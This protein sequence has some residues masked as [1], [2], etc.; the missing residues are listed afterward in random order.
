MRRYLLLLL[1][2]PVFAG[3]DQAVYLWQY[4]S[5]TGPGKKNARKAFEHDLFSAEAKRK[6]RITQDEITVNEVEMPTINPWTNQEEAG[7]HVTVMVRFQNGRIFQQSYDGAII[8]VSG[9]WRVNPPLTKAIQAQ[10]E[11]ASRA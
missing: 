1:L 8:H 11:A 6:Y 5:L 9:G 3:C 10:L 2:V 7:V 4:G